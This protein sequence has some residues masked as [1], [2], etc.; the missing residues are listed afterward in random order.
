MS[1]FIELNDYILNK[2]NNLNIKA[3]IGIHFRFKG[4]EF[5][6]LNRIQNDTFFYKEKFLK[7]YNPDKQ[8]VV[9]SPSCIL[10][11]FFLNFKN[12]YFKPKTYTA[13]LQHN[14]QLYTED[15]FTDLGILS[16]CKKIYRTEGYFTESARMFAKG[17]T[18]LISLYINRHNTA[19]TPTNI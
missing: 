13:F 10:N 8:Y 19:E 14:R 3:D 2:I 7:I 12:V 6:N 1:N 5:N 15:I 18:K 17:K 16:K 11:D 9:C 4:E